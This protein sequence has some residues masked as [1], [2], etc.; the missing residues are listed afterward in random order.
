MRFGPVPIDDAEGAILAHSQRA[1]RRMVKKGTVLTAEILADLR[2][3]GV[4][5]VIAARL[6]PDDVHEDAAAAVLAEAVAGAN[7]R[8]DRAFTGRVN[9]F[10]EAAGVLEAD[11][12]AIDRFNRFDEAITLATLEAFAPVRDGTM[13][14]TVK[15]IPF[16]APKPAVDGAL[17]GI[18]QGGLFRVRPFKPARV[19][20]VASVLPATPDKVLAK[21]AR[22]L[23]ERLEPTGATL[24]GERRV[25]H[26][27]DAVASAIAALTNPANE[28]RADL[29][30][31]F[32]A[33]AIV[34]R[35]DVI[36]AAIEAAGG[37]ITHFGMPVDPG[38]LLLIGE[39]AG[40]P[41]IGAP[42][43]ARSPKENG[44][45][46][47]LQR[48]LAGI[49]VTQNDV[50]GMGIGGLL[51][52][53]E[54]RPQPRAGQEVETQMPHVAAILL[55]AGQ[56]RRMGAANKL[57][58][59]IGGT[60]MVR[61]AA[62]AILESAAGPLVVVTGHE[63]DKVRAALEG[64]DAGFVHNPDYAEGLSTSLRTGLA[65]LPDDADGVVVCL[66]DMPGIG[67]DVIDRLVEAFDPA[68][69]RAAVVPTVRGKRGNPVLWGR[70]F[71]EALAAV[72]GD[73]GA[74]HLIGENADLVAEVEIEGD[75][76]LADVDTP[77]ALARLRGG[78]GGSG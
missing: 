27:T 54:S 71:F 68:E 74:R 55:A 64:V 6:G 41:V 30:L 23:A 13:V 44:F 19:G 8:V 34:D 67:P 63:P 11:R 24:M 56:S 20:F 2:A 12:E 49:P 61:I 3:A 17:A 36:P 29:V 25:A 48:L 9:L 51:M 1:G 60:P 5:Q 75:A 58:E 40:V 7:I 21:T 62:D 35:G 69:G 33:S 59:E 42:G 31:V 66:G 18:G 39:R 47:V 26:S 76:I 57:T 16:A 72:R 52:E 70:R 50:T 15:I 14:A 73:V 38:N 53:I 65:A 43:C 77:E 4:R 32:G 37:T 78:Q 22:V 10:S 45:D 28:D 46:W